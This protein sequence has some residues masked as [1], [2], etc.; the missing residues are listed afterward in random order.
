MEKKK[1][2]ILVDVFA[3]IWAVWGLIIFIATFVI[4]YIPSILCYLIKG[5]IGQKI[6]IDIARIWMRIWLTL[7]GCPV[8]VKGRENFKKGEAY[9][10]V[11]NHNALLDPPLSSPFIPGP[12]K[13]IAKTSFAKIPIFGWYYKKGAVLVDRKSDA[14]RRRSFEAMKKTLQSGMHMCIY[15]E[16]TRNRTN[17]PLKRFYDGAFKLSTDSNK[18]IIPALLF[19]TKKAMPIDKKFYLLPAKLEIHFLPAVPSNDLSTEELKEKVFK[20]MWDYYTA[21]Q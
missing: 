14:S 9:V 4:F 6:F 13:T 7:I 11:C 5:N 2:N 17:D 15:P 16:G 19:N 12:N 3:R 10:V 8:T 18:A 20:I 1:N 21:H